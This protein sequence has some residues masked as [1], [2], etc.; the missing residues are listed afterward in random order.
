[1]EHTSDLVYEGK[2][3]HEKSYPYRSEKYEELEVSGCKID[4][5]D[6]K[7]KV[8][9]EIKKSNK[10]EEAHEW[11][12]K[13]YI[14]I[15]ERNGVEGVTGI[16]EYPELRSTT[17]IVLSES[18]RER[19]LEIEQDIFRIVNLEN[20]PECIEGRICKRCSYEEFCYTE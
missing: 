15:L 12:V 4:Y 19:L 11:Q 17:K 2:L 5:F 20:C 8:I 7:N 16:L 6:A 3:I 10:L 18:D 1:M 13:Y 9:H 14:L